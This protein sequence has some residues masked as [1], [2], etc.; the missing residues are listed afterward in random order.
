M[1]VDELLLPYLKLR[2]E[3][4]IPIFVGGT[5]RGVRNDRHYLIVECQKLVLPQGVEFR[6]TAELYKHSRV[7]AKHEVGRPKFKIVSLAE[8][9]S[10][11]FA[12]IEGLQRLGVQNCWHCPFNL[13]LVVLV[14]HLRLQIILHDF[15]VLE[16][17]I[18]RYLSA[19][20]LEV[21]RHNVVVLGRLVAVEVA[22]K[23]GVG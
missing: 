8:S 18:G 3:V 15:L 23:I 4:I 19:S 14:K 1:D 11:I 16:V 2:H 12:G 20:A 7:E 9:R 22:N 10:T 21:I 6:E 13:E 5:W 17:V